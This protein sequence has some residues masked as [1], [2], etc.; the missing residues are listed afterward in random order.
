MLSQKT[1]DLLTTNPVMA[2]DDDFIGCLQLFQLMWNLAHRDIDTAFDMTGL[3]FPR[4]S[5]VE[6]H[7][8]GMFELCRQL[9]YIDSA[10]RGLIIA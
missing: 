9:R 5:Y 1:D 10:H 3:E 4:F 2:D 8:R 6:Q 7:R